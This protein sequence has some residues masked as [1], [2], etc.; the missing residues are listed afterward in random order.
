MGRSRGRNFSKQD[1]TVYVWI[2]YSH[3]HIASRICIG[4][5]CR[6]QH[7][8]TPT[9]HTRLTSVEFPDTRR[10][11]W[12]TAMQSMAH[13][14][15]LRIITQDDIRKN[16][17]PSTGRGG[18]GGSGVVRAADHRDHR[19]SVRRSVF[20]PRNARDGVSDALALRSRKARS[21]RCHHGPPRGSFSTRLKIAWPRRGCLG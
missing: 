14:H 1:L 2:Q 5:N 21:R 9:V 18:C 19:L 11:Y 20:G 6:H 7:Y 8:A 3:R 10:D 12:L 13:R 17:G 15:I 4:V 16:Y